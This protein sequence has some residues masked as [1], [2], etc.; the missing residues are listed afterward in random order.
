MDLISL[1]P[2][3]LNLFNECPRCFYNAY[4]L[5]IPRP[6]GIMASLSGGIDLILKKYVDQ[7]RG[8]LPPPF[9]GKL[10]GVLI[11][12]IVRMK[13]WRY[14][15]TGPTYFDKKNQI[16]LIGAL[17]DCLIDD[18]YYIP[19]D[20]KSKGSKPKDDGSQYYQTQL[21]CYNLML[22]AQGLK[23]REEGWLVY[24]YPVA[25]VAL[26]NLP[27]DPELNIVFEANLFKL[28]CDSGR[29][30]ELVI[31][32]AECLRGP[33]PDFYDSCEHCRYLTVINDLVSK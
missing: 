3:K 29:A 14:W 30:R 23:I 4:T 13:K 20:W 15:K 25:G 5:K 33:R 12:D 32:A 21:D 7:Y 2:S 1:S 8:K 27:L 11:D 9:I 18:G 31:K 17:D 24:V 6:R 19:L 28:S 16:E 22:A 26:E 10:P